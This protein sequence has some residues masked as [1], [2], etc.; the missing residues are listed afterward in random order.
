MKGLLSSKKR[1]R[2]GQVG[3]AGGEG[4]GIV[5]SLSRWQYLDLFNC[6]FYLCV[7]SEMYK[8]KILSIHL[9]RNDI[10]CETQESRHHFRCHLHAVHTGESCGDS[11]KSRIIGIKGSHSPGSLSVLQ[12]GCFFCQ[13]ST[14]NF[15]KW[16]I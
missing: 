5:G 3:R 6:E 15:V 8:A 9:S 1:G 12:G 7:C 14:G 10:D 4:S 13:N 16:L 11:V 2:G